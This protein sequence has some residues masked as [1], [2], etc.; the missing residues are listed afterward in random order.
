M[1]GADRFAACDTC[2]GDDG[3][4]ID[5]G[6]RERRRRNRCPRLPPSEWYEHQREPLGADGDNL[7]PCGTEGGTTCPGGL[8]RSD[9]ATEASRA[10]R[11]ATERGQI[12]VLYP[13]GVPEIVIDAIDLADDALAAWRN[14]G[15]RLRTLPKKE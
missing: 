9:A 5:E 12:D 6:E 2:D 4:A 7:F 13:A 10:R 3:R 1:S 8:A 11:W 15:H 14:E